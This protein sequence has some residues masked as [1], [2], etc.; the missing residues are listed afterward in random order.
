M[1]IAFDLLCFTVSFVI[2]STRTLSVTVGVGGWGYPISIRV[3]HIG[4]AS[5]PLWNSPPSSAS[6]VDAFTLFMIVEMTWIAPL[7]GGG[8]E[9]GD[10]RLGWLERKKYLPTLDLERE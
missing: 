8:G 2:P 10:D 1:Y 4:S 5:F 6:A 9:L 7:V 3:W